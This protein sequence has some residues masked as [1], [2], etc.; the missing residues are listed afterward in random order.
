MSLQANAKCLAFHGPLLYEAKI[1]HVYDPAS[2]VVLTKDGEKPASEYTIPEHLSSQKAYFI[3]YKGWKST[4]DEWV[5][6]ERVKEISPESIL[7]QKRLKEQ[8]LASARKETHKAKTGSK[9]PRRKRGEGIEQIDDFKKRPEV[10]I[11]MPGLLKAILVDDW[12]HVTKNHQLVPLPKDPNVVQILQD[13]K[14]DYLSVKKDKMLGSDIEI[15]QE[16]VSGLRDYFDSALGHILLY[17]FERQQYKNL[18]HD[19]LYVE[20]TPSELYGA[21]HLLRLMS[22]MPGLIAQTSM[23]QQ[24]IAVLKELLEDLIDY[25]ARHSE[26]LFPMKYENTLPGYD[27]MSRD[28]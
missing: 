19:E 26:K 20:K 5:A 21:E 12:E 24:L 10:E 22:C 28:N 18:I 14:K 2:S 27:A 23:D 4:W 17:R 11:L 9:Q 8:I 13:F 15:F 16:V 7:E 25:M 3:H 1:L 6:P